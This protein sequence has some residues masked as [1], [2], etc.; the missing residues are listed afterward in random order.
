MQH[1]LRGSFEH[2]AAAEAEEGITAEQMAA[3]IGC[4]TVVVESDMGQGMSWQRDHREFQVELGNPYRIAI[5]D[6]IQCKV[7]PRI[8]RSVHRNLEMSQ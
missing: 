6:A 2:A 3:A 4:T 7:D 5:A 8:V 1:L